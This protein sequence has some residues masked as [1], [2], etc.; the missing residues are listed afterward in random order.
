MHFPSIRS[1]RAT[2]SCIVDAYARDHSLILSVEH[3]NT[4]IDYLMPYTKLSL[5][6]PSSH[7][8][9]TLAKVSLNRED[10][11]KIDEIL[12]NSTAE[13]RK[14]L[15]FLFKIKN[16]IGA[17]SVSAA[18]NKLDTEEMAMGAVK[19]A[20]IGV[21]MSW[22]REI[23]DGKSEYL[24]K[25]IEAGLFDIC[26]TV[27][28][29]GE[30]YL[31]LTKRTFTEGPESTK[32]FYTVLKRHLDRYRSRIYSET[33]S[34]LF[35]FYIAHNDGMQWIMRLHHLAQE[36]LLYE[37]KDNEAGCIVEFTNKI[38]K[39]PWTERFAEEV[40]EEYRAPLSDGVVKWM[41]GCAAVNGFIKEKPQRTIEQKSRGY[42]GVLDKMSIKNTINRNIADSNDNMILADGVHES[43]ADEND[44]V[45]S[46]SVLVEREIPAS[47]SKET[48]R[49]IVYIG[50][51]NR[52]IPLLNKNN[53]FHLSTAPADGIFNAQ[54][55]AGA[56]EDAQRMIKHKL[57]G[58]FKI[59][60]HL[61]R[62]RD[63]FFLFRNDF[64]YD[65]FV[66]VESLFSSGMSLDSSLVDE[67]LDRCFGV[68]M[69]EFVD[70][71]VK[72]NNFSLIYK[73]VFPYNLAVGNIKSMLV[74][75]F[76]LFWNLRMAIHG[77][78]RMHQENRTAQ[79]CLVAHRAGEL[80]YYYFEKVLRTMWKFKGLPEDVLYNPEKISKKVEDILYHLICTCKETCTL[81]ILQKIRELLK[82]EVTS[83][84]VSM[85]NNLL[86]RI[87]P[88]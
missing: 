70:V 82:Q 52:L 45:W 24:R 19:N 84:S 60:D 71:I 4:L 63:V 12:C 85:I 28:R 43:T 18:A 65:L 41:N 37:E 68:E 62:I 46:R 36:I 86:Q 81:S 35:S 44:T 11:E 39:S 47:I 66:S 56:Y 50:R 77:I 13:T 72:N 17:N 29:A 32:P 38:I 1:P 25:S 20:S 26:Y 79:T 30:A 83:S 59:H 7:E 48:A 55:I 64:S 67:V 23:A 14:A 80:E 10:Q 54:W 3:K 57:F 51:T 8:I 21:Y 6:I 22:F 33:A 88:E 42:S 31:Y 74:E 27:H 87:T 53:E 61:K 2:V 78:Y 5:Y 34:D 73:E 69:A 58:E 75:G 40:L 15:Y 49:Q 76:D 9:R 16:K